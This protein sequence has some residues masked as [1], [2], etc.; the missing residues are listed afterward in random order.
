MS[1]P[2]RELNEP[3]DQEWCSEHNAYR[4]CRGCKQDAWEWA[5]ECWAEAARHRREASC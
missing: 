4:P 3:E 1:V 2:D 5:E